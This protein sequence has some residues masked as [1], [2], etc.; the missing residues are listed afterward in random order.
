MLIDK[1]GNPLKAGDF[2]SFSISP[3]NK[4]KSVNI[5]NGI[6]QE[7]P[8][9]GEGLGMKIGKAVLFWED[10]EELHLDLEKL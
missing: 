6:L 3:N 8:R 7:F 10:N 1:N 9:F 5:F 4:T 2:V